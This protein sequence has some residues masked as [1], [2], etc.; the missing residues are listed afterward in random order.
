MTMK[1]PWNGSTPK[2]I[3][4]TMPGWLIAAAMRASR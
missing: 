1:A 4:E 3:T 2:S